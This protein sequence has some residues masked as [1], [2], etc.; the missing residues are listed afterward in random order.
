MT[1]W[2]VLGLLGVLVLLRIAWVIYRENFLSWSP[3][4]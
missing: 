3:W 1:F 4:Q 2:E